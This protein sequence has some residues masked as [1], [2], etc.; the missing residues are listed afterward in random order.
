MSNLQTR[1]EGRTARRLEGEKL[2]TMRPRVAMEKSSQTV[3]QQVTWQNMSMY[4]V[5]NYLPV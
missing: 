1:H 2:P 3:R 4:K 5:P